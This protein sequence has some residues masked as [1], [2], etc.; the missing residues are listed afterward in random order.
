MT[1]PRSLDCL[2]TLT[3]F[4]CSDTSLKTSLWNIRIANLKYLIPAVYSFWQ[5]LKFH[6]MKFKTLQ[7]FSTI[8][9]TVKNYVHFAHY[10]QLIKQLIGK[11]KL[12]NLSFARKIMTFEVIFDKWPKQFRW[13]LILP[14]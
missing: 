11:I 10:G 13:I 12:D 4:R 2:L 9:V 7:E 5:A 6:V 14:L 3:S 1:C 8:K